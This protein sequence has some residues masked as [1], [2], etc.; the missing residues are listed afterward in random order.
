MV[1]GRTLPVGLASARVEDI[2][3]LIE[4]AQLEAAL[5]ARKQ[6]RLAAML[7][8][9]R[10]IGPLRDPA[11][12][13]WLAEEVGAALRLA[14]STA[15]C[16]LETASDLVRR[17]PGAVALLE[18]G[19]ISPTHARVLSDGTALLPDE[20]AATVAS[21]VLVRAP[22]QT[23]GEF[24]RAIRR[25]VQSVDT[26]SAEQRHVRAVADRRV[27]QFPDQDGMT[28]LWALLPADGAAIVWA[29]LNKLAADKCAGDERTVDQ[30]RADALVELALN[31]GA[32]GS[33]ERSGGASPVVNVTVGLATLLGEN[34]Q[35]AEL[36]GYGPIPAS[37][38]RRIADDPSGT[39]RRLI[40]DPAGRLLD[41]DTCT[42]RPPT[43]LARHVRLRDR[44]CIVPGCGRRADF[45]ELDHRVR[46]PNGPTNAHNLQPLCK[47][48]HDMKHHGGWQSSKDPDG[49]YHWITPTGHRYVYRPP[50]L[51]PPGTQPAP[52][53]PAPR[54]EIDDEPP[55]F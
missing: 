17:L 2:D 4:I 39:W 1:E 27:A 5:S 35:P 47:H 55:P 48:H 29:E 52:E 23:V 31:L 32:A 10:A 44:T 54:V 22:E 19:K 18:A 43:A 21:R 50:E 42:Y 6:R 20:Q 45:C 38:A 26:R 9:A 8:R 49:V 30:R 7:E 13:C 28:A 15:E 33:G 53:P 37:M 40:T 34:D 11:G 25:A 12:H 24:R 41:Y 46:Y 36:D 16:H 3:E 51:P 14:P